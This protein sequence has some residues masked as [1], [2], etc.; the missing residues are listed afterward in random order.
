MEQDDSGRYSAGFAMDRGRAIHKI[1]LAGASICF[2][3]SSPVIG[4]S[5]MVYRTPS[6]A[7]Q[8]AVLRAVD[9]HRTW[10]RGVSARI[11]LLPTA[12]HSAGSGKRQHV[13]RRC[14]RLWQLIRWQRVQAVVDR[15][16]R[17]HL[18]RLHRLVTTHS[19][20]GAGEDLIRVSVPG[21]GTHRHI[22][23]IAATLPRRGCPLTRDVGA[24]Q[25]AFSAHHVLGVLRD[26]AI[27]SGGH[28]S[29]AGIGGGAPLRRG[30]GT[31]SGTAAG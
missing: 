19:R 5:V 26:L 22:R 10:R 23:L 7:T 20:R 3:P 31:R 28:R 29:R 11:G 12:L 25:V 6:G 17:Y 13:T 15:G 16:R 9:R 30:S 4:I 18:P 1:Q 2:H 14:W 27:M 8:L 21:V 24:G